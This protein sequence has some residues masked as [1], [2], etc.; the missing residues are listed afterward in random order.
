MLVWQL[1]R[2]LEKAPADAEI[3]ILDTRE[4]FWNN[5]LET[6]VIRIQ[7]ATDFK[8]TLGPEKRVFAIASYW[9]HGTV[10]DD[11]SNSQS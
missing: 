1:L 6:G 8:G 9:P 5:D 3:R 7:E 11:Q 4:E 2:A 10:K